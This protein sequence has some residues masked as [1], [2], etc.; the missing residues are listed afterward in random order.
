M[1]KGLIIFLVLAAIFGAGAI[2]Y[3]NKGGEISFGA[4]SVVETVD[5]SVIRYEDKIVSSR[6]IIDG[7]G[8]LKARHRLDEDKI[9]IAYYKYPETVKQIQ[10]CATNRYIINADGFTQEVIT[11]EVELQ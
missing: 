8:K 4:E 10:S 6:L 3:S 11:K 9:G 2:I 1:P 7:S 5:F